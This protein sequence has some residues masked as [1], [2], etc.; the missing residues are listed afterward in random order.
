[1]SHQIRTG[2]EH[3][4]LTVPDAQKT[5]QNLIDIFGWRIRWQG[6]ALNGGHVVHVG[7][8]DSYVALYTPKEITGAVS[9]NKARALHLNHI[10]VVVDDLDDVEK[11]V[12]NKGFRP[13]NHDN[14]EP[15]RRFYFDD[16]DG[17]EVEV[18]SYA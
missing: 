9:I 14:Y 4:N 16:D 12:I 6:P 10:G 13:N 18:V 15:G 17:L 1:M 11:R 3:V 2:L 7:D 8:E 5:A